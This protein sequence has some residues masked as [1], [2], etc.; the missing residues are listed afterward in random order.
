MN[1]YFFYVNWVINQDMDR[2][3]FLDESHIL[4]KGLRKNKALSVVNQRIWLTAA[5]LNQKH[6]SITLLSST[7]NDPPFLFDIREDS[8]TSVDFVSFII[9]AM[10]KRFLNPNDIIILDNA[11]VHKDSQNVPVLINILEEFNIQLVYLPTY[12]PELNPDELIFNKMKRGI[13][14]SDTNWDIETRICVGLSNITV[15]D[16]RKFYHHCLSKDQII[17]NLEYIK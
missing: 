13:R 3:K 1:Y 8:N 11:S 16:V 12:S 2:I 7:V 9:S 5:D 15:Q 6:C 10:S 4:P 14:N 17:A